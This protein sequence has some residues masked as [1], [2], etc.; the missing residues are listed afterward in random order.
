MG[1]LNKLGRA[2]VRLL[3]IFGIFFIFYSLSPPRR[4]LLVRQK[5]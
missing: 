5:N 2:A 3:L 1:G 4:F